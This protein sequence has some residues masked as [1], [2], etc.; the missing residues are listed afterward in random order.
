MIWIGYY[1]G[2]AHVCVLLFR[3]RYTRS[4][5]VLFLFQTHRLLHTNCRHCECAPII[6]RLRLP[7][8]CFDVVQFRQPR[9]PGGSTSTGDTG[10]AAMRLCRGRRRLIVRTAC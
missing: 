1:A 3:F 6:F 8:V 7:E 10:A 4:L 5:L 2:G 9:K